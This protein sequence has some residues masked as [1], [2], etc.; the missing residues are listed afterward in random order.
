MEHD[1]FMIF[2]AFS[3]CSAGSLLS[4][5]PV[6]HRRFVILRRFVTL[7]YLFVL[8]VS[9]LVCVLVHRVARSLGPA[10]ASFHVGASASF[11]VEREVLD[12]AFG[13]VHLLPN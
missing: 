1:E 11:V 12:P 4:V 6:K 7:V 3:K 8:C 5:V 10:L 9:L 13:Y 2:G